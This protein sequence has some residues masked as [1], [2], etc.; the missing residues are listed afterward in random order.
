MEKIPIKKNSPEINDFSFYI[1]MT[2]SKYEWHSCDE[3]K[4]E[5]K[6]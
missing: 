2:Y 3:L 1:T 5:V 4:D 6:G